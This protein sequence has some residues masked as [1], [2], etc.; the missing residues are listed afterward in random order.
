MN[1]KGGLRPNKI[2]T[3]LG[4]C[5]RSRSRRVLARAKNND[6]LLVDHSSAEVESSGRTPTVRRHFAGA[7]RLPP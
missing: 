7:P 2:F 6:L 4:L 5:W 1:L 3:F